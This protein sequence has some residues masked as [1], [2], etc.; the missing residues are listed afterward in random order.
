MKYGALGFATCTIESNAG[1]VKQHSESIIEFFEEGLP[2]RELTSGEK[3][4]AI[5]LRPAD[6]EI[7]VENQ[8]ATISLSGLLSILAGMPLDL[9]D[10]EEIIFSNYKISL[11]KIIS[12]NEKGF[13]NTIAFEP[14]TKKLLDCILSCMYLIKKLGLESVLQLEVRVI[15]ILYR[16]AKGG[17]PINALEAKKVREK[18]EA[19]YL[20]CANDFKAKYGIHHFL[21]KGE[22]I[23]AKLL[24]ENTGKFENRLARFPLDLANVS[25]DQAVL[26]CRFNSM[27]T[28][29]FRITTKNSN[30]QGLPKQLRKCLL[31]RS[32]DK[33]V[34]FDLVSSQVI[35]LACLAK[36][37]KLISDYESG[38]DIYKAAAASMFQKRVTE[39]TELER[40]IVKLILLK[41]INGAGKK[42]VRKD[43]ELLYQGIGEEEAKSLVERFFIDYPQMREFVE[44]T[45]TMS[46]YRLSSGR[47]VES[48]A[49]NKMLAYIL[50]G[51]EAEVLKLTLIK[52]DMGFGKL[53]GGAELYLCIHDSI[54]VDVKE[55]YEI[56]VRHII[57]KSFKE[58]IQRYFPKLSTVNIKENQ[59]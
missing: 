18:L 54:I 43:L 12:S 42:E 47:I 51:I 52:A 36:E 48:T 13:Q 8:V 59:I 25:N 32:G 39:V 19:E 24:A 3:V 1:K 49:S 10:V 17:Y 37:H 31:P 53:N 55:G 40:N 15:P 22:D 21:Y 41:Y 26:P 29:T 33:L 45:R 11:N 35:I 6:E 46:E 28:K 7:L 27:G 16:M 5:N 57:E 20:H 34:E 38:E 44:E 30:V 2:G 56:A 58:A 50:Q 9:E 4:L 23:K 14:V